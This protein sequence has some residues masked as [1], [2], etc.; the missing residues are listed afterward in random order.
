MSLGRAKLRRHLG[1]GEMVTAE[2]I[3]KI[4]AQI[5]SFA[6]LDEQWHLESKWFEQMVQNGGDIVDQYLSRCF[7]KSTSLQVYTAFTLLV[8]SSFSVM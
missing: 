4:N 5:T 6:H 8:V 2:V 7:E 1:V 3:A